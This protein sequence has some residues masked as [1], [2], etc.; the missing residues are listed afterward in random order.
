MARLP[1]L[2]VPTATGTNKEIFDVLQ[3]SLG[4]V[5]NMTKVMG[6]SPAVLQAFAQ[7]NGAM[8]AAKLSAR[9]REQIALLTAESNACTYCLSAHTALGGMAG[10]TPD[11]MDRARHGESDDP[12]TLAALRFARSVLATRGGV[13]DR[14]VQAVRQA[15]FSEAEIAEIVGAVALNLFTNLFNR[16]FAVEVDFP[17][18]EA[19]AHP[20]AR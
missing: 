14:D 7:F 13:A 16:A 4:I 8:S 5:P 6:N 20:A 1:T 11:Q 3:R 9:I 19:G 12:R 2:D 15:G 10:L 17:L 18:V